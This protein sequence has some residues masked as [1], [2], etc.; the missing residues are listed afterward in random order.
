M[1]S[2]KSPDTL[3]TYAVVASYI[4]M[5]LGM[6]MMIIWTTDPYLAGN[7]LILSLSGILLVG[8]TLLRVLGTYLWGPG[9]RSY[10]EE[11]TVLEIVAMRQS[12]TISELQT[13][14]GY[15]IERIEGILRDALM[16]Q[17]LTGYLENDKFVR[18]TSV[19]PW[20]PDMAWVN[21]DD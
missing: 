2:S 11:H 9:S 17:K 15:P 4:L 13:E 1:S 18:D 8:G 6:L 7:A 19:S 3:G 12:V 5:I 10:R 14:T 16:T 20:R 21:D